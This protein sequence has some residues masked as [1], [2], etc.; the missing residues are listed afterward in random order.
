MWARTL[1]P[2]LSST[3]NMAFG[4]AS[5]TV[6]S[7]SITPSFFGMS[8]TICWSNGPLR[9]TDGLP[10]LHCLRSGPGTGG[11]GTSRLAGCEPDETGGPR[12]VASRNLDFPGTTE[13]SDEHSG[14]DPG[15]REAPR[16]RPTLGRHA[17]LVANAGETR[18]R[19]YGE[20]PEGLLTRRRAPGFGP[21]PG[22]GH[23]VHHHLVDSV[24]RGQ[25][26]D[27]LPG[28]VRGADHPPAAHRV[29][30]PAVPLGHLDLLGL[31]DQP[32]GCQLAAGPQGEHGQQLRQREPVRLLLRG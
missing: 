29:E 30:Q 32:L 7:I 31:L 21:H 9:G 16:N 24:R 13:C 11:P 17:S 27:P 5:T 26:G 4:R 25:V 15:S 8:S 20:Q 22:P 2:L 28:P 3:R 19:L 10:L 1:C 23:R 6:P 14:C 18:I 12:E